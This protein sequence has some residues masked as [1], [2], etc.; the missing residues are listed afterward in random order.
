MNSGMAKG[1]DT[2]QA[3][4]QTLSLFGKD[5]ARRSKSTCELSGVSGVA[6]NIYEIPPVLDD[7]EFDRCLFL[8]EDVISQFKQPAKKLQAE[9]V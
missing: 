8:S 6:L 9:K 1:Y 3:R 2:N 5:L 7:P 4:Q